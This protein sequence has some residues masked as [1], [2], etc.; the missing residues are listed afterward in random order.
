MISLEELYIRIIRINTI[1][2]IYKEIPFNPKL[3]ISV[4][5]MLYENTKDRNDNLTFIFF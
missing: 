3:L 4:E 2:T 5:V 1:G